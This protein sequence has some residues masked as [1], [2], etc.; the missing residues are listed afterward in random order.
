MKNLKIIFLLLVA[1]TLFSSCNLKKSDS[2]LKNKEKKIISVGYIQVGHESNWR[3]AN[4]RSFKDTFTEANGYKL[5]F[6]DADNSQEKQ[7]SAIRDFIAKKVDYIVLAPAVETGWDAILKE[8]KDANIPVILSDRQVKVMDENL[9]LCWVG[10]NFL[11]EGRESMKWLEKYL[12]KKGRS[13]M[14]MNIVNLQ[15]TLGSS[16]QKGR[17]KGIEEGIRAH[18]NWHLVARECGEFEEN[19]GRL[20]MDKIIKKIGIDQ[21]DA[22]FAENDN[23]AWGAVE[24]IR[25]AGKEPGKDIIVVCFDAVK[26]TFEKI[27]KGEIN[28]ACECNPLHGPRVDEI[29]KSLERGE[30]VDRIQYVTEGVFDEE[31]AASMLPTRVY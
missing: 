16:A 15:G 18:N 21:I 19:V 29:I 20:V 27:I 6:V 7:F 9:Y 14:R 13:E 3:L 17:T 28:C 23:M 1:S 31:N 26:D 2:N 12:D 10:G 5:F 24:A 22:V 8:A 25:A 4:T 11:R 30:Y